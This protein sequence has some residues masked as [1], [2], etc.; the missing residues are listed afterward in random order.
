MPDRSSGGQSGRRVLTGERHAS[1][2]RSSASSLPESEIRA[3][4]LG[5]HL[6]RDQRIAVV[7]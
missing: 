7:V 3:T 6:R 1:V 2:S 5:E 4:E